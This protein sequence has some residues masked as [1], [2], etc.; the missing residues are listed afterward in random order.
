MSAKYHESPN[1]LAQFLQAAGQLKI[2][3]QAI[4][5]LGKNR[6]HFCLN[7]WKNI[8]QRPSFVYTGTPPYP[9]N[10]KNLYITA[11]NN[12]W[13]RTIW[14]FLPAIN[15]EYFSALLR[16]IKRFESPTYYFNKGIVYGNLGV[17]QAAQMKL[18][19]GF[20]NILKAL[21]ED[22][23]YSTTGTP[24]GTQIFN[25]HLFTQF[26]DMF[27]KIDFEH[28]LSNTGMTL[29]TPI[30]QFINYFLTSL[31][32]DQR[33]FFDYAFARAIQNWKIWEEK[34]N[35]FS[36]NR[37]LSC[38]QDL[39]LFTEDLLKSKINPT[40]IG[41]RPYWILRNLVPLRTEFSG[42][43]LIGCGANTMSD[44][45]TRLTR[46]LAIHNEL[47]RCL[48]ILATIRNYSSHNIK[49]GTNR[50]VFYSRY[51]D[52]MTELVRAICNVRLLP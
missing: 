17:S 5:N 41:T 30:R 9:Y 24:A 7:E 6:L 44:L 10:D 22:A 16:Q 40:V 23:I 26:E 25:R 37:L 52:I 31:D 46:N 50:N 13:Y 36:A 51:P 8:D 34:N 20:A 47:E 4:I 42:I 29:P 12:L 35:A 28:Y 18:D 49:S 1:E 19:E 14:S 11:A 3:L 38:T 27:V 43:S 32:A 45:D 2:D 33:V 21:M 39:C 15:E 48:K